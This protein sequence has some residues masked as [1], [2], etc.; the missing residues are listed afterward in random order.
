M[1]KGGF[2][3]LISN[4]IREVVFGMEDSVVSTLGALTGI[5]AGTQNAQVVI[6]SG[7]V[8]IVVEA[9]SMSAGSYL[10]SKSAVEVYEA[11]AKQ[12]SARLLQERVSDQESLHDVLKRKRFSKKDIDLVMR[13]LKRERRVWLK[14]VKR[15][16]YR[17]LPAVSGSPVRS[18]IVMGIFFLIGGMFPLTPYLILPIEYAVAPSVLLAVIA[19]FG[20][21]VLK[22]KITNTS[23]AKSGF[24][25]AAISLTAAIIGFAVGRVALQIS[26]LIT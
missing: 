15:C 2:K 11:R 7:A 6:I 23:W 21:G 20:V 24:E 9:L 14:E 25:M 18:G 8:L 19:L 16:E 22:A 26:E 12:D 1:P 3:S 10:S 17:M 4:S 5:A 13:A